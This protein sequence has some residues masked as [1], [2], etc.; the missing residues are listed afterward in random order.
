M[1]TARKRQPT[2]QQWIAEMETRLARWQW[3]AKVAEARAAARKW[4]AAPGQPRG[5]SRA[6]GKRKT[7][8]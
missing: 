3:R 8:A 6:S 2:M 4:S 5:R 7:P 1:A